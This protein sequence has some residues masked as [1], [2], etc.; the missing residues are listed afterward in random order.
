[1]SK[2]INIVIVLIMFGIAPCFSQSFFKIYGKVVSFNGK[3]VENVQ[4]IL[5]EID[6]NTLTDHNGEFAFKKIH[7]GK[8]T[9]LF[10]SPV[11]KEKRIRITAPTDKKIIVVLSPVIVDMGKIIISGKTYKEQNP[12]EAAFNKDEIERIP[13]GGNPFNIIERE[14]GIVPTHISNNDTGNI[15]PYLPFNPFSGENG[16]AIT[17]AEYSFFGA[18]PIWTKYYYDY[19]EIPRTT[20]IY[21]FPFPPSILQQSSIDSIKLWKGTSPVSIESSN[22]S[23]IAVYPLTDIS[24]NNL[25]ITPSLTEFSFLLKRKINKNSGVLLG[26][27]K[28][29]FEVTVWPIIDINS[30]TDE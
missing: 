15:I 10:I 17:P 29:L 19:I 23:V 21:G 24:E 14:G 25:L 5:T 11:Y 30:G 27:R 2:I 1:M 18:E 9:I 8:Y 13:T 12:E 7:R 16:G 28:S 26:L 3:P 6:R 4:V 20:H 22:S